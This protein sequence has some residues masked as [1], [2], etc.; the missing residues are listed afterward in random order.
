MIDLNIEFQEQYKRLDKL[1]KDIYSSSEGVSTYIRE[2]E[3]TP[4]NEQRAVYNWDTIYKQLK[5]L[6][7]MR[8]QLAHEIAIDSDFCTQSDIDWIKQFYSKILNCNDPLTL[9]YK[10][11]QGSPQKKEVP[12][13]GEEDNKKHKSLWNRIM[14]IIRGWFS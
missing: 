9:A 6:R 10:S 13:V 7:W 14:S 4:Y 12:H 5:H 11:K 1:C 2:M 3:K 8:N